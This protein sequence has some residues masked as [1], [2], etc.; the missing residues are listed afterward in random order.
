MSP[1]R[2]RVFDL[3]GSSDKAQL[4]GRDGKTISTGGS[5]TFGFGFDADQ[6]RFNPMTLTS[7][8]WA[9]GRRRGRDR[10]GHAPTPKASRSAN[11]SASRRS[12]RSAV[13]DLGDREFGSV[14]SLG[15]ATIAVFDRS[16]G[17]APARQGGTGRPDLRRRQARRQPGEVVDQIKPVL[18]SG[19]PRSGPAPNRPKTTPRTSTSSSSSSATS[20]LP[21]PG[22]RSWSAPSSPSTPSRSRSPSGCGSSQRCD[23][24]APRGGRCCARC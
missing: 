9:V 20:C 5:P 4:I 11:G 10:R 22:S 2:W 13:H 12:G 23:R 19:Q 7:G 6:T 16:R 1:R 24:S 18:P 15:G 3:E 14:P 8:H 17:P 21:S